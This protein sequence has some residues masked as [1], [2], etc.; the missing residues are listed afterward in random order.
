MSAST[1]IIGSLFILALVPATIWATQQTN[2]ETQHSISI[3]SQNQADFS[4]IYVQKNGEMTVGAG[5]DDD[6]EK[7]ARQGNPY[8]TDYL[9]FETAG[10]S[11]VITDPVLVDQIKSAIIPMQQQGNKMQAVGEQMQQKGDAIG[12]QTNK[13]LLNLTSGEEDPEVKSQIENLSESM[14]VLGKEMEQLSKVHQQLV[15]QA[16]KQVIALAQEAIQNGT[17]T[18]IPASN[19]QI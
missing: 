5:H 17:A 6:W 12:A 1:K 7:L 15:S 4:W 13:L 9:W 3:I 11:Y 18:T 16:E 19:K 2:R 14:E 10:T 8:Q